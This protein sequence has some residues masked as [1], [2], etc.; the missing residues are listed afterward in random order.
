MTIPSSSPARSTEDGLNAVQAWRRDAALTLGADRA[1]AREFGQ[2]GLLVMDDKPVSLQPL[3]EQPTGA[4]IASARAGRPAGVGEAQWC[5]AL[6]LASSQSL[7]VTHAAFGLAED[8]DAVL[9]V[10]TPAGLD[11]PALLGAE[12][13]GL[14]ALRRA[15]VE[16]VSARPAQEVVD[17][18]RASIE[19]GDESPAAHEPADPL[20]Q[21]FEAPEEVLVMV[22]G[23][24]LHL[25]R[26]AAQALATARSGG[27]EIDGRPIGL[28]CDV[29]GENLIVV[30]DLGRGV[31]DTAP[32][33]RAAVLANT[34]LMAFLGMAV[35]LERGQARLMTRWHLTGQSAE[36]F[37]G[38]LRD[39]ARL[40]NAIVQRH[41]A[42]ANH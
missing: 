1:V 29:D 30:A 26:S 14:L 2:T 36:S 25:G 5:D 40:A 6:L 32:R 42:D 16:G 3:S 12:V 15:V 22:H 20:A 21:Q 39:I 31:L 37:A 28:A 9:I 38:W 8:G 33:R 19:A 24:M 34:E 4:W 17:Q 11:H 27:L 7:I 35:V 18:L 13:A 10:R 41:T 23:A